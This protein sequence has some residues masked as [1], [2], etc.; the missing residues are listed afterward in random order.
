MDGISFFPADAP[1]RNGVALDCPCLT[2]IH[3]GRSL[4]YCARFGKSVRG[5]V[6]RCSG[7]CLELRSEEHELNG[8][9]GG[10]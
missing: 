1:I 6:R 10:F 3:L 9:S 4:I 8:S 5:Y 2:C 7:Y